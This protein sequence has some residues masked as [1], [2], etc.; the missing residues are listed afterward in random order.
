MGFP[1]NVRCY[2][3]KKSDS[4][5]S[6]KR[7]SERRRKLVSLRKMYKLTYKKEKISLSVSFP[8]VGRH[9]V[10]ISPSCH[11]EASNTL[12]AELVSRSSFLGTNLRSR[13]TSSQ[14][15][16]KLQS[17]RPTNSDDTLLCENG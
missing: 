5:V 9:W 3:E 2:I 13:N 17:V 4:S 11:P 15:F 6:R 10:A 7:I 12:K 14:F 8:T 1:W 16:N